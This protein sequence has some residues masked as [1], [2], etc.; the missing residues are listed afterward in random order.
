MYLENLDENS[1]YI[2]NLKISTCKY[3]IFLASLA[4]I[5]FS[6]LFIPYNKYIDYILYVGDD[7]KLIVDDNFFQAKE[8]AIYINHKKYFYNVKNISEPKILNDKLYYEVL[9]DIN[10]RD[11][12]DKKIIKVKILKE[13]TTI[14][15][16]IIFNMKGWLDE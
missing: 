9:I 12:S 4:L 13:N 11:C 15:K 6:I 5:L 3:I 7:F 2:L 1:I 8:K 14:F 16:N 10:I